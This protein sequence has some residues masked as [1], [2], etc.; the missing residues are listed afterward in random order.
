MRAEPDQIVDGC[1][2]LIGLGL[3]ALLAWLLIEFDLLRV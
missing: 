2:I 3:I 1:L